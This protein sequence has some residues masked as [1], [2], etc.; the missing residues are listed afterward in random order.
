[1][2]IR[3]KLSTG[4][5]I[6]MILF[7]LLGSISYFQIGQIDD[8]LEEIMQGKALG[9][10][11]VH[12]HRRYKTLDAAL[13]EKKD[14]HNA[15]FAR[16]SESL[17]EISSTLADRIRAGSDLQQPDEYR[18][19]L[20]ASMMEADIAELAGSLGTFLRIPNAEYRK[21]ILANAGTVKRELRQLKNLPLAQ[22]LSSSVTK[23]EIEFDKTMSLVGEIITLSNRLEK[24]ARELGRIREKIDELLSEDF[25]VFSR[26]DIERVRQASQRMIGAKVTIT[27]ILIITGLLDVWVFRAA[28]TRSITKPLTRLRDAMTE[29]GKGDFDTKVEIESDDEIGQLASAFKQMAEQRKQAE[30]K[31]REARDEQ[32]ARVEERTGELARANEVMQS[33]VRELIRSN[34]EL[35]EFSYIAAHDLKAPL[36]S[37][38]TLADWI[39]TDYGDKFDDEGKKQVSLLTGKTKQMDAL[40]DSVLQYSSIRQNEKMRREVDLNVAVLQA[41]SQITVPEDVEITVENELPVL[42][43]EKAHIVQVFQC[44]LSN[45]V[46]HGPRHDGQIRVGCVRKGSSWQ[47]SVADNGPGIDKKYFEKIFRIFQTLSSGEKTASTGI[48]LSIVKK[49]VELNAGNVWVESKAGAGSTF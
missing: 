30:E 28:I 45:A 17:D 2:T 33:S 13:A 48:G 29:I 24:D 35:Q 1:M 14:S 15:L 12:L 23:L 43:C 7:L 40:L 18:K 22:E 38:A 47:F 31:L 4:I 8:N 37:I 42:V 32:E 26:T 36:R 39:K 11:A 46:K 34:M 20:E 9:N 10:K 19:T 16:V 21:R 3:R 41:I 49:I 5:S 25:E 44:L 27:L 6:L